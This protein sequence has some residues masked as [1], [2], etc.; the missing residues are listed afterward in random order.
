MIIRRL[1]NGAL[2]SR[3]LDKFVIRQP[4]HWTQILAQFDFR[5]G[6]GDSAWLLYGIARSIKPAIAVEIGSA[7]GKS[8]CFVGMALKENGSGRLYAVDPHTATEW[9]DS[10]SVETYDIMRD[11]LEELALT[12]VVTIVRKRS[13]ELPD[14]VPAPI[15]LL[16]IDGDHSYEGVKADWATCEPRMSPFG[17]VVFHDTMWDRKPNDKWYRPDMGVPRF[18]EELRNQGYPVITIEHDYGVSLVQPVRGGNS[19]MSNTGRPAIVAA[20]GVAAIWMK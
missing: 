11:H 10:K 12:D 4:A 5:S 16:F 17:L 18:V 13:V 8:A 14:I 15:D 2:L 6:L 3:I 7:R 20:S 9:N 1:R 19:L